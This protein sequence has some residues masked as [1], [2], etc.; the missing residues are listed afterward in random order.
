MSAVGSSSIVPSPQ[1]GIGAR[2]P[3]AATGRKHEPT[4]PGTVMA[5]KRPGGIPILLNHSLKWAGIY[6]AA[7][8]RTLGETMKMPTGTSMKFHRLL[9]ATAAAS[10]LLG[11]QARATEL[12]VAASGAVKAIL[13][14]LGP[15]FEKT[16]SNS[17]SFSFGPAAA[18]KE[19]IDQG[20]GFDVAILTTP[21]VNALVKSGKIAPSS[22]AAIARVG[23]GVAFRNGAAKPDVGTDEALKHTL[24]NAKSI[25]YGAIGASSAGVEAMLHKL[26]ITDAVHAKMK[27]LSAPIAAV[28]KG[29][30]EIG[31]APISEILPIEGVQLAGPFP[32][33]L[34][35]YLVFSAGVAT[36]SQNAESAKALIA[37][38]ASKA[39]EPVIQEKGM[40]PGPSH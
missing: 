23:L 12:K 8:V 24:L 33:D 14:Q 17:L 38:L 27:D 31:F 26:G 18:L 22:R 11:I 34:Q 40:Q 15:Q 1:T 29:E 13:E 30:V 37:F 5:L 36:G 2:P 39:A 16:S 7:H 19:K 10:L 32:A 9:I 28:A 21:L 6:Q 3:A 25:G 35:S 4:A 20:N